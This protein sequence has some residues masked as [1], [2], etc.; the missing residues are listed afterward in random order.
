MKNDVFNA[1][2]DIFPA[3][4]KL[5]IATKKDP[6]NSKKDFFNE[7]GD[8]DLPEN[9]D[10]AQ[11]SGYEVSGGQVVETESG[12]GGSKFLGFLDQFM[13]VASQGADVYNKLKYGGTSGTESGVDYNAKLG[14]DETT[15]KSNTIWY[16]A[17]GIVV[18]LI[19]VGVVM[20]KKSKK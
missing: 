18:V 1:S 16:V 17:G 2:G 11:S 20:S 6:F 3:T 8:D 5:M 4:G 13:G 10:L 15:E 9:T 19:V 14:D 12:G 7:T